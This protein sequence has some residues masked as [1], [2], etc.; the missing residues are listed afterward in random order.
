MGIKSINQFFKK[1]IEKE[2]PSLADAF[3][4]VYLSELGNHRIAIDAFGYIYTIMSTGT[5]STIIKMANPLEEIDRS[6]IL[7]YATERLFQ[8]IIDMA[9][10]GITLVWVWDG[11]PLKEKEKCK[12]ERR[13]AK[14]KIIA[15][16]DEYR[17]MLLLKHPLERTPQDISKY[18]DLLC[19][20]I[21]ILPDEMK[22]FRNLITLYGFPNI[23]APFEGEKMCA[24]LAIEG[25]VIGV[26]SKDTDNY[27]LGTPVLITGYD[28]HVEGRPTLKVVYLNKILE[29]FNKPHSWLLD[30]CIL[31]GCDFNENLKNISTGN[32]FKKLEKYKTFEEFK[33]Q[34]PEH[35]FENLNYENCK[36]LF[37]YQASGFD[38]N[39][40][41]IN[42]NFLKF[43]IQGR[44]LSQ[45]FGLDGLYNKLVYLI[46][47]TSGPK[48]IEM[49]K[50]LEIN[51]QKEVEIT[52]RLNIVEKNDLNLSM[53]I[54]SFSGEKI[55]V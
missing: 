22:H 45:Q 9:T 2:Y 10:Y 11:E 29:A 7:K 41:E 1:K 6:Q 19:Q 14:N 50:E 30:L 44:D 27:A 47:Q 48:F 39:S 17:K 26:W 5:S 46:N 37:D 4:T 21:C 24:S 20:N 36:R 18:K 8:F 16:I 53:E 25:L 35:S 28:K 38:H 15:K 3:Q 32:A 55:S 31:S 12:L 40:T 13:E 33:K 52:S 49:K 43:S 54:L 23:Q 51:E 42:M 34:E